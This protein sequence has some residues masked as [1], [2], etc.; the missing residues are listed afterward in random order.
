M[1]KIIRVSLVVLFGGAMPLA[2]AAGEGARSSLVQRDLP[3][4]D[5]PPLS[6][7][8]WSFIHNPPPPPPR[9]L[10]K[11]DI[12]TIRVSELE[13]IQSEGDVQRRKNA[14]FDV[15]LLDWLRLDDI[16]TLKPAPQVDGDPR[17]RG[18][19]DQ[20]FRAEGQME[21]A[22]RLD[23]NIA[24]KVVDVRPNQTLVVEAH[25]QIIVDNEVW[26]Y[27]LTGVCRAED[28]GPDNVLLSR[29][30]SDMK[31]QK[32]ERGHIRDSYRRGF[33]TRILDRFNPF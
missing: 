33:I 23:I 1:K 10:R 21:S 25:K 11:Y 28:I 4:E 29:N 8:E 22:K 14:S 6:L 30:I 18:Q 26:E 32:R 16:D 31:F 3:S 27:S 17:A 13:R 15:R 9:E 2:A 12:I 24:A 7:Q 5:G 20:I 19:L